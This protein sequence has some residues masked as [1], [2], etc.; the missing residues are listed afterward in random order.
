MQLVQILLPLRDNAGRPYPPDILN[1]VS[2]ELAARFGGVTAYSRAPAHGL[3]LDTDHIQRDDV[4]AVEVM[5]EFVDPSWWKSFRELLQRILN[6]K[7]I[8][9][10]AHVIDRL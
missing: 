5:V 9:V 6:Q 1:S 8:V 2:H 7:E 10:R 4:V 3:W